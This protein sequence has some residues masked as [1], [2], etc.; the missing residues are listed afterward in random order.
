MCLSLTLP[1]QTRRGLTTLARKTRDADLRV[2]ARI[3]LKIHEGKFGNQA[4]K[5][6]GCAPSTTPRIVARFQAEGIACLWDRRAH[7]GGPTSG[8]RDRNDQKSS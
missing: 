6:L 3:L 7:N 8:G 4:A 5:E 2:R 1:R